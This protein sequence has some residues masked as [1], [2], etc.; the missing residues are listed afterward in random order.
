MSPTKKCVDLMIRKGLGLQFHLMSPQKNR[1]RSK[2]LHFVARDSFIQVHRILA[3]KNGPWIHLLIFL[4]SQV[5]FSMDWTCKKYNNKSHPWLIQMLGY[6]RCLEKLGGSD[7][8]KHPSTFFSKPI[9]SMWHFERLSA[10]HFSWI[11]D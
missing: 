10:F 4:L 6:Y 1:C 11:C 5:F 3:E 9:V 2:C 7:S 8:D